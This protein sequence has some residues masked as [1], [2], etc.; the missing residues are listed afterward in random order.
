MIILLDDIVKNC[1]H[2]YLILT[3]LP[4]WILQRI[5]IGHIST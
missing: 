2:L 5:Y 4:N 3:Y 1:L